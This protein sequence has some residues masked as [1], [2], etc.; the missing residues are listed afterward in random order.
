VRQWRAL[1]VI[2]HGDPVGLVLVGVVGGLA[3][4]ICGSHFGDGLI[5]R[6]LNTTTSRLSTTANSITANSITINFA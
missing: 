4:P 3:I 5:P 1:G 6:G 2:F